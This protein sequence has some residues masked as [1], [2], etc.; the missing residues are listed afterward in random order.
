VNEALGVV[1]GPEVSEDEFKEMC[2]EASEKKKDEAIEVIKDKYETKLDRLEDKLS[3]EL[4]DLEEDKAELSHRRMEEAGK[5]LENIIGLIGG[6]RRSISTSLTKRRMT[7]KAKANLEAS[8]EDVKKL[9]EE[10]AAMEAE[11]AEELEEVEEQWE[12]VMDQTV[13]EPVSPYKK[14]IFIEMFGLLWLPYYAF[15]KGDG[16]V[17]VPAFE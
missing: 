8:E 9:E 7:S 11:L 5:G 3:Q 6:R 1:A 12:D 14:N 15:E 4:Q 16:W 13:E 10:M 17:T 2:A